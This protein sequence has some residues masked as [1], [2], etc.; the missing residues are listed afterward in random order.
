MPHVLTCYFDS[1]NTSEAEWTDPANSVDGSTAT[2]ASCSTAQKSIW[3][4]NNTCS[5]TAEG[6][7]IKVEH[8]ASGKVADAG[9]SWCKVEHSLR[10]DGDWF[11]SASE[12]D[13]ETTVASWSDWYDVTAEANGPGAEAWTFSNISALLRSATMCN[14]GTSG[15]G[16]VYSARHELRITWVDEAQSCVETITTTDTRLPFLIGKSLAE[17]LTL[18]ESCSPISEF[19]IH[20]LSYTEG[21][22]NFYSMLLKVPASMKESLESALTYAG[23]VAIFDRP[24]DDI[25]VFDGTTDL[26]NVINFKLTHPA[27][28]IGSQLALIVDDFSVKIH[29]G[30]PWYTFNVSG[31]NYFPSDVAGMVD[32]V[33]TSIESNGLNYDIYLTVRNPGKINFDS[34]DADV[35]INGN[36][37][38][39]STFSGSLLAGA[40][41][42]LLISN[43]PGDGAKTAW[44]TMPTGEHCVGSYTI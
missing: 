28:G 44:V 31:Y 15:C 6:V 1:Y 40:S 34:N 17:D 19:L 13:I 25:T 2:F 7:V 30:I 11:S 22:N 36:W 5:Q 38:S 43:L 10:F 18:T 21:V 26:S 39:V 16:T 3:T 14:Q 41:C 8:R 29:P 27:S 42:Q 33:S 20:L 12:R 4:D 23:R 35:Y 9:C 37:Q 24:F 32:Y